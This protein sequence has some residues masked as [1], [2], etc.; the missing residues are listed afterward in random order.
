MVEYD[1]DRG[2]HWVPYAL[3]FETFTEIAQ[4]AGYTAPERI[5]TQPSRFLGGFFA[6]L[7]LV[8]SETPA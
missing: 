1:T 7:A 8:K 2:N 6:A 4:E 3:S 5:G